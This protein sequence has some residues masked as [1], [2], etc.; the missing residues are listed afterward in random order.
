MADKDSFLR[1]GPLRL[2]VLTEVDGH[3]EP[4]IDACPNVGPESCW[5]RQMRLGFSRASSTLADHSSNR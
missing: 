1:H 2:G 3:T 4:T 5:Q